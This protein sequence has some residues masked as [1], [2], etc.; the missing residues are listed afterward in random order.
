MSIDFDPDSADAAGQ[1]RFKNV[2]QSGEIELK[3][4]LQKK[5]SSGIYQSRFFTTRGYMLQ[6]WTSK[7][8]YE[9]AAE[10]SNSYDLRE[11]NSLEIVNKRNLTLLFGSAKFKLE[12]RALTDE[13]CSHWAEFL[14]SKKA[15]HSLSD[16]INELDGDVEF[17]TDTFRVLMKLREHDQVIK[18]YISPIHLSL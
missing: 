8:D 18:T 14:K 12:L 9:K 15:L 13:Q 2:R 6:Y 7:A 16:L 10:S 4:T 1:R 17:K 11:M 5:N 3:E